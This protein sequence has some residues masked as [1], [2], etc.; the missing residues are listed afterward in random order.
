MATWIDADGHYPKNFGDFEGE[1][2]PE[3]WLEVQET[4]LGVPSEG[5]Y[6]F[7]VAPVQNDDGVWVQV[8]E[9][10]EIVVLPPD[11]NQ[12]PWPS[13]VWSDEFGS[14]VAPVAPDPDKPFK[15]KWDEENGEW[16]DIPQ[17]ILDAQAADPDVELMD[18]E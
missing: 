10:K 12:K 2:L 18:V 15:Q 7:E 14:W 17:E 13:W 3:G 16:V 5:M 9:E 6:W 4:E 1:E 8:F 11:E